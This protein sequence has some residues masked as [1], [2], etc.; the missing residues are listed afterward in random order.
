MAIRL[1]TNDEHRHVLEQLVKLA[2]SVKGT[3][4]HAEGIEYTSLMVCF[5]MHNVISAE[6]LLRLH[7]AFT[8]EWFPITVGYTVARTMFEIDVT[9]HYIT[10]YPK[11]RSRQYIEFGRVLE[12]R[13]MDVCTKHRSS[14]NPQWCFAM[15][16]VWNGRW[17]SK[18]IEV[19][20]KYNAVRS[21]FETITKKGKSIPFRN[22]SG[23]SIHQMAIEV[24][25]EEAYDIFYTEL[26]S[27]TH[28]DVRL[29]DRFLQIRAAG[30]SWSQRSNE[31]DVG[32]VFRHAAIFL[33]CFLELFAK[34]FAVLKKDDIE[35]CWN[36][37]KTLES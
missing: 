18:E 26:S 21:S 35:T 32:N 9:S 25:H 3:N 29:A 11:E 17:A 15:N 8:E 5:L 30:M 10:L 20:E 36:I 22:W 34:Q 4:D 16:K 19:N 31:F 24:S 37:G 1:L 13:E 2:N 23:K 28:A 6:T 27:F 14:S 7:N 33:T 12:K